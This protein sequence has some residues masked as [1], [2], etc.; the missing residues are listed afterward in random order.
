MPTYAPSNYPQIRQYNSEDL[1]ILNIPPY[2]VQSQD[3]PSNVISFSSDS[4]LPQYAYRDSYL[5]KTWSVT[6]PFLTNNQRDELDYFYVFVHG[7]V[8]PF[9]WW[10]LADHNV[11]PQKAP[12]YAYPVLKD[13]GVLY[14]V[15]FSMDTLHFDRVFKDAWSSTISLTEAHPLE[16]SNNWK[17]AKP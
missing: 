10:N 16:I 7:T 5:R 8:V 12:D 6:I 17:E 2:T 9:K 11:Q 13:P 4:L 1:L 15:R 3:R 14:F